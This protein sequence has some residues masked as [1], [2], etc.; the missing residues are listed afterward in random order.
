MITL[1]IQGRPAKAFCL[2]ETVKERWRV[3]VTSRPSERQHRFIGDSTVSV[4]THVR[5]EGSR[6]ADVR[7]THMRCHICAI[8][9]EPSEP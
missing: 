4:C 6:A 9:R 7:K 8:D 2:G 3:C 1:T 5:F